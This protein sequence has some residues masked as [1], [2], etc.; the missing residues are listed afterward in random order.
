MSNVIHIRRKPRP[1]RK[2]YQPTAPYEVER[3][4]MDDGSIMFWVTDMRP[5]TYRTL[6]HTNDDRGRNGYAKHDAE[7]IVRGL[8]LLVQYGKEALPNVKDR[9]LTA[10]LDDLNCEEDE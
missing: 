2:T 7:Q 1:L 10:D 5:D 3:E 9:E 6:C 8:N 4:D